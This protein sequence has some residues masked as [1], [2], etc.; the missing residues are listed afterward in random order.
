MTFDVLDR[1]TRCFASKFLKASAGTGK[2]F[3]IEN[4]FARFLLEEERCKMEEILVITFTRAARKDLR[5]RILSHLQKLVRILQ[6]KRENAPDYIKEIFEKGEEAT[7][8]ARIR[9][10]LAIAQFDEAQIFTIHSFCLRML[11]EGSLLQEMREEDLVQEKKKL[12][13]L[14]F[15]VLKNRLQDF[16]VL[17]LELLFKNYTLE[18]L[19]QLLMQA[20]T[21]ASKVAPIE[22]REEPKV[23][24]ILA[25]VASLCFDLKECLVEKEA[26]FDPD[27]FLRRME[28]ELEQ[29]AFLKRVQKR[30]AIAIVDEFQDT[31][32]IQWRIFKT[33]F[34]D[35]ICYLVGDPKQS[36]YAFRQADIYTYLDAEKALGQV[37]HLDTNYRSSPSLVKALNRLFEKKGMWLPKLAQKLPIEPVQ[38]DPK[39][40]E[41]DFK[42]QRGSIHFFV[43]HD[44]GRRGST[45]PRLVTETERLFPFIADEIARLP[46]PLEEIAILVRDR[47]QEMRLQEFLNRRKIPFVSKRSRLLAETKGFEIW[48]KIFLALEERQKRQELLATPLLS[49][50]DMDQ[51]KSAFEMGIGPLFELI[52]ESLDL[53]RW[54]RGEA[55]Y[56]ELVQVYEKLLESEQEPL[57]TLEE[58][59]EE[60][61]KVPHCEQKNA[62][63]ILTLHMSKGLEFGVV[64]ALAIASRTYQEEELIVEND[65]LLPLDKDSS[66]YQRYTEER[67]AE[68]ARQLYVG[69]TRAKWR[70]YVPAVID[71]NKKPLP[72]GK[73]SPF[74]LF[75]SDLKPM[76]N[77]TMEEVELD[78]ELSFKRMQEPFEAEPY[79][80]IVIPNRCS[81]INS[82]TALSR[83][84]ENRVLQVEKQELALGAKTGIYLHEVLEHHFEGSL[85]QLEDE[86][87]RKIVENVL[88]APIDGFLLGE[89]PLGSVQTEVEFLMPQDESSFLTGF[90]DLVAYMR[91]K[92]YIFDWKSN[93]LPAYTQ[94]TMKEAMEANDYFLQAKIYTLALRKFLMRL[95]KRPFEAIFGGAYYLFLRGLD[96]SD[97]GIFRAC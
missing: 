55:L 37:A 13:A 68:K 18:S 17:E 5:T 7:R 15:D 82:F 85:K 91:G 25:R 31:D 47:Y 59:E 27:I 26:Y 44:E 24:S 86:N 78:R 94:A 46:V 34:G 60:D 66:C 52:I 80:E 81:W 88:K 56:K 23:A 58:I 43:V 65:L 97:R 84:T 36:I 21:K 42:D 33:C 29:E 35:K 11:K 72:S 48:K 8:L 50:L 41:I 77:I 38:F 16:T 92:Y 75:F 45:W 76:E 6:E 89:V 93:W 19:V 1:R 90:I 62:V 53:F 3:A 74:E 22:R 57:Q 96:G 2:T 87:V 40:E 70:L 95:E 71:K 54:E 61:I 39:K 12:R 83:K 49:C 10:Q 28:K 30:Y 32:P 63:Q 51:L 64:F 73:A 69:L 79:R 4:L 67:D 9:L 20:M 14:V